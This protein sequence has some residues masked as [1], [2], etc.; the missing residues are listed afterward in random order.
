MKIRTKGGLLPLIAGFALLASGCNLEVLNPGAILDEDLNTP[1]LMPIV[2]A[3]AS[4]E[5][6]DVGDGYAF[7]GG[8]LTDDLSGTGSY[9]STGQYRLGIFDY[10]DSRGFWEQTHEAAWAA[11]EAW[12]RLES[13]LGEAANTSKDSARLFFLQGM[14][15]RFMGEN[16]CDVVYDKGP[17]QDRTAA[18]DSAVIA[19][20]RAISIGGLAG[21]GA[22]DYV[23]GAQIGK[24]QASLGKGDWAAAVSAAANVPTDFIIETIYHT[25]ANSNQVYNETWGRAEVGVWATPVQR[26][27]NPTGKSV[28]DGGLDDRGV[29]TI[30]GQWTD[31]SRPPDVS[32][33]V[34]ASGACTGQGSGAHQGAGG[35][36][37]HYRQ[38]KHTERG[39][40]IALGKGTEARLIEAE[41]FL[42][43]GDLANFTVKVNEVRA[44]YNAAAIT[45]PSTAGSLEFENAED[46][47][48]SILDRERYLTMWIEG[49]RLWDLHRWD[50]PFLN[51]G[52][53]IGPG[54][55]RRMS[56]MP[57][58]EIECTLNEA[59]A[60][61][62]VCTG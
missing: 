56:C 31:T 43:N 58:P 14:A 2:V 15:H 13:V 10:L 6:N 52:S 20:N 17:L 57:I 55:P 32:M 19:F 62:S 3:G 11:G 59:I 38:D 49:R 34:T 45:Q 44:F 16:F 23:T 5:L 30:C 33:G 46:D 1:E 50:H 35:L 36:T 48:W 61:S 40:N 54:E 37:A 21:S 26:I 42:R 53:L 9:F 24:A 4:A 7:T 22:A 27:F 39:A 28:A 8:R 51:G 29:F 18:F 47:G 60:T 41:N 12:F 25:G